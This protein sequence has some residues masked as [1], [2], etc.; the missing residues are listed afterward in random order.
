MFVVKI[1]NKKDKREENFNKSVG[2]IISYIC[3]SLNFKKVKVASDSDC[4]EI[5][6]GNT[7][8]PDESEQIVAELLIKKTV[9]IN[10]ADFNNKQELDMFLSKIKH[11]CKQAKEI[12]EVKYLPLHLREKE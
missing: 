8:I 7:D 10:K 4:I 9:V 1:R 12:E 2:N 3:D 11:F 6:S 5:V